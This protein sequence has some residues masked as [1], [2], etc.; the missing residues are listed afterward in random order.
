MNFENRR[1]TNVAQ[2]LKLLR[3]QRKV[4]LRLGEIKHH[5]EWIIKVK[6]IKEM[7]S[8]TLSVMHYAQN[9]FI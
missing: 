4:A 8:G 5:R 1:K 3:K 9:T 6:Y 7:L 2:F